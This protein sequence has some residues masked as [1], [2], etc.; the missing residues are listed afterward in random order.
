[1]KLRP[2]I[3]FVIAIGFLL[4]RTAGLHFHV[5]EGRHDSS[6]VG[7]RADDWLP[8]DL[9]PGVESDHHQDH[10]VGAHDVGATVTPGG[11]LMKM[12]PALVLFAFIGMVL[13]LLPFAG[14][15]L[16][17]REPFRPRRL[18]SRSEIL[19]PSRGP[20]LAA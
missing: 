13:W 12:I 16:P 10:L 8:H 14:L 7:V 9:L 15:P 2:V 6:S 18:R 19:P 1:M 20:P 11:A 3:L 4:S 5:T 17:V